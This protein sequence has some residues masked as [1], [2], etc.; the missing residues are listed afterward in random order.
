MGAQ[1][2][3][4]PPASAAAK[5]RYVWHLPPSLGTGVRLG[6]DRQMPSHSLCMT[7]GKP[8]SWKRLYVFLLLRYHLSLTIITSTVIISL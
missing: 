1:D 2:H 4:P 8:A 6:E 5:L 3:A 7:E